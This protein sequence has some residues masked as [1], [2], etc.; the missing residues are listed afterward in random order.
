L[1]YRGSL[2]TGVKFKTGGP[3]D[4]TDFD[5]DAFIVSDKL[6]AQTKSQVFRNAG[7]I[8]PINKLSTAIEDF[9][10]KIARI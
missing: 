1:G 9:F 10:K 3:F 5:V 2:A 4:P 8:T 7:D 6:A